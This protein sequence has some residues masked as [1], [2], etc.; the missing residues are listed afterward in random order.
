MMTTVA[1]SLEA[2]PSDVHR[3][4]ALSITYQEQSTIFVILYHLKHNNGI[5]DVLFRPPSLLFQTCVP[6]VREM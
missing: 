2:I 3:F 5:V 4:T 1:R 6:N